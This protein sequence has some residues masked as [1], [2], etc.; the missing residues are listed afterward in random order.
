MVTSVAILSPILERKPALQN[1]RRF[2]MS[3]LIATSVTESLRGSNV[4]RAYS[5]IFFRYF[6][7]EQPVRMER[8]LSLDEAKRRLLVLE[9]EEGSLWAFRSRFADRRSLRPSR[10]VMGSD[11]RSTRCSVTRQAARNSRRRGAHR[12][13]RIRCWYSNFSRLL[14]RDDRDH[15][16]SAV[17]AIVAC[18]KWTPQQSPAASTSSW[19]SSVAS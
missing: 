9:R 10:R 8:A 16:A 17:R 14:R 4:L 1:Q 13:R 3:A 6:T 12:R 5:G 19:G 2:T 11:G 15:V 7:S 18:T